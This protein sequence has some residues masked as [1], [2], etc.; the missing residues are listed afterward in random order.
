MRRRCPQPQGH[1]GGPV[2]QAWMGSRAAGFSVEY[3][4][5]QVFDSDLQACLRTGAQ[6]DMDE[7]SPSLRMPQ[8]KRGRI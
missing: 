7:G 5:L 1:C 3:L 6:G 2:F 8:L 4:C